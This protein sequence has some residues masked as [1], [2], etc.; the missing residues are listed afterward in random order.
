MSLSIKVKKNGCLRDASECDGVP[1]VGSP[2]I[3]E[4]Q[5]IELEAFVSQR[6][7]A[8]LDHLTV[9]YEGSEK[10]DRASLA[11]STKEVKSWSPSCLS[12]LDER[13]AL[14]LRLFGE[15]RCVW[16]VAESEKGLHFTGL[17]NLN[18]EHIPHVLEQKLGG[19]NKHTN[20][21]NEKQE[22]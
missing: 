12:W 8:L 10:V 19:G 15:V 2:D 17:V 20:R 16:Y 18:L 6:Q 22:N 13:C 21:R 4:L 14:E 5:S 3:D 1:P 9:L 7:Q 11:R